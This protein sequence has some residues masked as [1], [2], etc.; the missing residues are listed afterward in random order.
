MQKA[1]SICWLHIRNQHTLD[2]DQQQH[3]LNVDKQQHVLGVDVQPACV[4]AEK[5]SVHAVD[6]RKNVYSKEQFQF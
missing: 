6:A 2:A 1:T 5:H 3:V 4:N